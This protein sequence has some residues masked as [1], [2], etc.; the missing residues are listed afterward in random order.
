MLGRPIPSES[1]FLIRLASV[2][3]KNDGLVNFS[4][5]ITFFNDKIVLNL[6]IFIAPSVTLF[7]ELK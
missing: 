5:E 1:N 2:N 6:D 3:L 4:V 7:S